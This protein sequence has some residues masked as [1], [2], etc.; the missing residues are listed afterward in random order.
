MRKLLQSVVILTFMFS[1][2]QLNAQEA[3]RFP[4]TPTSVW[5]INY[6]YYCDGEEFA[7]QSGDQEYKYFVNG[8]TLIEGRTY[9][10]LYKNG[11]LY[12]ETPVEIRNKYMGALR[13]SANRFYYIKEN[14]NS[15][16]LLYNFDAKAGESICPDCGGMNYIVGETDTLENGRKRF[17]IDIMTVHCGS[18]NMLIE[19]IGWLGGL[20]EGNSCYAHPGIRGSYLLCYSENEMPEY[21]TEMTPRC[22]KT[23]ECSDVFTPVKQFDFPVFKPRINLVDNK[24]LE[25]SASGSYTNSLCQVSIYS[26]TGQQLKATKMTLPGTIDV[27]TL[28]NGIFIVKTSNGINSATSKMLIR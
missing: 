18:A 13:D 17:F 16:S 19:G 7:H 21:I 5:R 3:S 23:V 25:I 9:F 1:G 20:L 8:D 2:I 27:T 22:A 14:E 4:I 26:L 6:E 15:E 24:I 12:L 11:F 28:G 10:K